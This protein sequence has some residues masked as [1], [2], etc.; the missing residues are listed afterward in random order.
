MKYYPWFKD[1]IGVI[2]R[3]HIPAVVPIEKAI[4]YRSDK[5]NEWT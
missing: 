5:K 3:K 1:Y 2:D 4:P